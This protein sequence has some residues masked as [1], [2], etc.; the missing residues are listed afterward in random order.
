MVISFYLSFMLF[1]NSRYLSESYFSV[2]V[3]YF[4]GI[5]IFY[6]VIIAFYVSFQLSIEG[7]TFHFHPSI[8]FSSIGKQTK[9]QSRGAVL[10]Y[11]IA[12]PSTNS[13][14]DKPLLRK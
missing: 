11:V 7:I 12:F 8:I 10:N 3:S 1:K 4:C 2:F 14:F 5:T 13:Y 6:T 9:R